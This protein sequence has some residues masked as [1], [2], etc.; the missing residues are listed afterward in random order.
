MENKINIE[1]IFT[2]VAAFLLLTLI[3]V[4][5]FEIM[6]FY[7]DKATYARVYDLNTNAKYWEMGYLSRW[8]YVGAFIVFGAIIIVLRLI[9]KDSV[10]VK[11]INWAFLFLFFSLMI[12]GFYNWMAT[13]FDH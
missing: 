2:G 6:D 5:P 13:G 12:I 10:I 7:A 11:K 9:K 4:I 1:T 3:V 8:I